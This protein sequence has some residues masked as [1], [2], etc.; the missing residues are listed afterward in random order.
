[1]I[2]SQSPL[3]TCVCATKNRPDLLKRSIDC[4]VRQ[5]YPNK[6][7]VIVSQSDEDSNK[8]I[9]QH[10][11]SL[12]REDILF[13]EAPA[14]L[15]L[16]AMRNVSVELATGEIVCQWDDD[17][18]YHPLRLT[19]QYKALIS[20]S[21]NVASL[22]SE[23]LK[24]FCNSH[25]VY[26]CDWSKEH[27]YSHR[28]LCGSIMFYK[29]LFHLWE[30]F[31][32]E[33][34]SQSCREEDLHVLEKLTSKGSIAP[35]TAGNQ[36]IYVYHGVNTYD[37]DHHKLTLDVRWGKKVLDKIQLLEN[38]DLIKESLNYLGL[39]NQIFVKSL[40]QLAFIHKSP[41]GAINEV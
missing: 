3:I 37:L 27:E 38:Q 40:D 36:Y 6:R 8:I 32:P 7:L 12:N 39:H 19:T 41:E 13:V 10:L 2:P 26:W 23:F 29:S 33:R 14:M 35:V 11:K 24:Y 20:D 4:Y 1:M 22:Y 17:D 21:R 31:Y 9:S 5:T 18:V 34:G 28:F 25:E 16:G 15:T 30:N